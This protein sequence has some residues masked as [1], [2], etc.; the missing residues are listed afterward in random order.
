MSQLRVVIAGGGV[1]GLETMFALRDLAGDR[2]QVTLLAPEAEFVY[3]P[4]AVGEPFARPAARH[5]AI[6]PMARE[7]G[8][9]LIREPLASVDTGAC[10]AYGGRGTAVAYDALVVAI[11][12]RMHAPFANATTISDRTIDEQLHGVVQD[13]EGGYLRSIAFVAPHRMSWPL[14]LYE[15]AL[16]SA[17][18][19]DE[20]GVEL[21]TTIVTPES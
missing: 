14:P 18:R 9:E 5:Y 17:A 15:L 8:V 12:A 10:I 1:A 19:A 16:M 13:I 3:R 4:M 2:V 20:M 21:R 11:G 6:T 7:A